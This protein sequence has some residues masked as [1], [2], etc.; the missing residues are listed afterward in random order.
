MTCIAFCN[1]KSMLAWSAGHA[2]AGTKTHTDA[3]LRAHQILTWACTAAEL[4]MLAKFSGILVE[5]KLNRAIE[6]RLA[7]D[8]LI[9]AWMH[10]PSQICCLALLCQRK[11]ETDMQI[12]LKPLCQ[13]MLLWA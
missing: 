3:S 6:V 7:L 5:S 10:P 13:R 8:C 2:C 9:A 4:C 11:P 12:S 1:H